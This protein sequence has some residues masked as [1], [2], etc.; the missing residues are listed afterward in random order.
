MNADRPA[1]EPGGGAALAA[2]G[3]G[4]VVPGP[5]GQSMTVKVSGTAGRGAYSLI[6]YSHAPGAPGP[7]AHLHREHEE[8]FYVL[9]GEL[10]LEAGDSSVTVRAGQA[11]AVPRGVI[12]RPS[13]A[14][15]QPVRFVFVSSPP[16]DEF[17]AELGLLTERRGGR[18]DADV[19]A[20]LGRRYDTVFPG[21]AHGTV[22]MRN[23]A[24]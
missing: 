4:A 9:E 7:P 13:N 23:E 18:L 12:H 3:D 11:A 15:D 2:A 20:D 19:L 10:T 16:M 5:T 14:S 6:E 22:T 1:G 21:L 8:A 24:R 17:F